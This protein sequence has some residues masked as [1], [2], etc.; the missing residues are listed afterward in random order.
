MSLPIERVRAGYRALNEGF[1]HFDAAAGSLVAQPVADAVNQVYT[2]AVANRTDAF[3]PGRRAIQITQA[4]REA[5]ADLL[6]A[7][8]EGVMFGQS[9]TYLTYHISRTLAASWQPGDEIVISRLD[10]DSNIRPWLQAA[11]AAGVVVRWAEF[12]RAT[13]A[14]PTA[15]YHDLITE[16]TRVVAVTAG[17]NANGAIPDVPAISAL[18]RAAGALCYVDG[19]H[20]TPHLPVAR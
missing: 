15:Q 3:E 6:G 13:G 20:A 4:A 16:R 1:A 17:S 9:A 10:H 11:E 2:S 8:A 12:D 19:V 5:A 14:L 18:T 7:R